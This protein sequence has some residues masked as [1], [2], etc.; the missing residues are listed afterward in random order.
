MHVKLRIELDVAVSA[1]ALWRRAGDFAAFARID[2][3][4]RAVT[5]L[6]GGPRQGAPITLEHRVL[7]HSFLRHGRILRWDRGKGYAFSD[8]SARGKRRGFPH[9]FKVALEPRGER[10][11]RL[12]V[13]V[14]GKWTAPWTPRWLVRAWLS[15][16][17]AWHRRLLEE[18]LRGGVEG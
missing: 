16:V 8:L 2:P 4:H 12:V 15:F 3:F 5:V 6:G 1:S 9:V 11:S 10:A 7:G 14:R 17:G 18:A 13:E